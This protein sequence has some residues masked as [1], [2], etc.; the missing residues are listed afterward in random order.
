MPRI[1]WTGHLGGLVVGFV[2]GWLLPPTGVATL[3]SLWRSPTGEQLHRGMPVSLR[4]AV[5]AGM[6]ILLVVGSVVAA[7]LVG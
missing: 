1:S 6:L 2:L 5:Y 7:N 4:L 3:G